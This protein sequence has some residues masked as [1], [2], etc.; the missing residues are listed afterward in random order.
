[1][2]LIEKN[3]EVFFSGYIKPVFDEDPGPEGGVAAAKGGPVNSWWVAG[4]DET[5]VALVGISTGMS[6]VVHLVPESLARHLLLSL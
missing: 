4:F 3:K 6:L 1:M 2:D 5:N